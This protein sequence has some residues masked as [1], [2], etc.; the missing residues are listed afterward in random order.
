MPAVDHEEPPVLSSWRTVLWD[1]PGADFAFPPKGRVR[2]CFAPNRGDDW[3][4]VLE[5]FFCFQEQPSCNP[6]R[7]SLIT[8]TFHSDQAALFRTRV[9]SRPPPFMRWPPIQYRSDHGDFGPSVVLAIRCGLL[10]FTPVRPGN[11][12]GSVGQT[13]NTD[14]PLSWRIETAC[15]AAWKN[16]AVDCRASAPE[17]VDSPPWDLARPVLRLPGTP[18]NPPGRAWSRPGDRDP[19]EPHHA[20]LRPR[21][22][23]SGLEPQGGSTPAREPKYGDP[24]RRRRARARRPVDRQSQWRHECNQGRG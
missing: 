10:T 20:A 21:A 19:Q 7:H 14:P 6:P 2:T 13:T 15:F 16:R 22:K 18:A 5:K 11:P 24:H 9:E 23:T 8:H 4:Y 12:T 1:D 3:G 17:R